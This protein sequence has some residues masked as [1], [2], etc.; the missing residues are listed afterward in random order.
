MGEAD[1][2]P[3]SATIVVTSFYIYFFYIYIDMFKPLPLLPHCLILP[4]SP[5]APG[6]S[7]SS[8]PGA[9][10]AGGGLQLRFTPADLPPSRFAV[11]GCAR[12]PP[13]PRGPAGRG[14]LV[15]LQR[16]VQASG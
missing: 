10:K 3:R 1:L 11:W 4:S 12:L 6:P 15:A 5:C 13:P 2:T 8:P 16:F 14:C 7:S 9:R